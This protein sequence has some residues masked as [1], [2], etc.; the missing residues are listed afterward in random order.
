MT[1]VV[2]RDTSD[3]S[4]TR[5]LEARLD[6]DG[7][8]RIEGQDLGPG[9]SA[10]FG[11][12]PDRVRVVVA[13]P[14]RRRAV[15][16]R[17]A[18]GRARRRGPP[19]DPPLVRGQRGHGSGLRAPRGGS[20]DRVR[21]PDR[22]LTATARTGAALGLESAT[23][24]SV[25][26][27]PNRR[28]PSM[29]A[30]MGSTGPGRRAP[31]APRDL[32]RR[33]R[34]AASGHPVGGGRRRLAEPVRLGRPARDRR[35][36]ARGLAA[37]PGVLGGPRPSRRPGRRSP[38]RGPGRP[39]GRVRAVR[40]PLAGRRRLVSPVPRPPSRDPQPRRQSAPGRDDGRRHRRG[41]CARPHDGRAGGARP[42]GR[43][44]RADARDADG[45]RS[46]R[47]H[48]LRELGVRADDGRRPRRGRRAAVQRAGRDRPA[49]DGPRRGRDAPDR[50]AVERRDARPDPGG[51]AAAPAVVGGPGARRLGRRDDDDG[52]PPRRDQGPRAGRAA[53][54]GREARGHRAARRRGRP[55][56]QQHP[57]RDPGLGAVHRR[58]AAARQ[59]DPRRPPPDHRRERAR[60]AA[61]R[62]SCSRSGGGR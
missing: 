28:R 21:Q 47:R 26:V 35:L 56:L 39:A 1:H 15:G 3:A 22:R 7:T 6:A 50:P 32:H 8:L 55:R 34:P 16:R 10:V 2:L 61:D 58:G 46:G 45:Q 62:R 40:V 38:G 48:Q 25:R 11:P 24:S 19:G 5:F 23:R 43:I 33:H 42:A 29:I 60:A 4:G 18:R 9:V 41:D 30:A 12:R 54:A 13:A 53:G 14:R 17:G 36:R 52:R 44:A 59:P 49:V 31:P 37:D 27:I 57:H 20:A 51:P